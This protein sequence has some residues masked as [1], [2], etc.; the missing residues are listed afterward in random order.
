METFP[1]KNKTEL[2]HRIKRRVKI[3]GCSHGGSKAFYQKQGFSPVFFHV[4]RIER[5]RWM[6]VKAEICLADLPLYLKLYL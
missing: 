3:R 1:L 4:I 2:I 6:M 5:K